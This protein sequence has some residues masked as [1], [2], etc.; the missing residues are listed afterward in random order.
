MKILDEFISKGHK[1]NGNIVK[2]ISDL[3]LKM[4]NPRLKLED[5]NTLMALL[6]VFNV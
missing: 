4:L 3:F 1:N 2:K 5:Q 6:Q